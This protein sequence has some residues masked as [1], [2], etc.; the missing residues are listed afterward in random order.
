VRTPAGVTPP[1]IATRPNIYRSTP[2]L[3]TW[4]TFNESPEDTGAIIRQINENEEKGIFDYWIHYSKGAY[5][6]QYG[7]VVGGIRGV[8]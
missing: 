2:E 5:H 7:G 4:I 6:I 3:I 1:V 8:K